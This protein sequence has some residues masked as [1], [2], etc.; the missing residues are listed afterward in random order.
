MKRIRMKNKLFNNADKLIIAIM[1]IVSALMV[2]IQGSRIIPLIDYSFMMENAYRIF[3]GQL[4]YKDFIL[5]YPPGTFFI[6]AKLMNWFGLSNYVQLAYAMLINFLIILITFNV[7]QML[8]NKRV[9]NIFLTLPIIFTGYVIYPFPIYDVNAGFLILLA[10]WSIIYLFKRKNNLLYCFFAG[11]LIALPPLFKQNVG[12][13]FEFSA[14]AMLL[15]SVVFKSK[16]FSL[17][18]FFT[19]ITGVLAVNLSFCIWLYFNHMQADYLYMIFIS[20]SKTRPLLPSLFNMLTFAVSK[21]TL[22]YYLSFVPLF[23]IMPNEKFSQN[24][25]KMALTGSIILSSLIIPFL[26]LKNPLTAYEY[27]FSVWYLVLIAVFTSIF[28]KILHKKI[29]DNLCELIV[30]IVISLTSLSSFLSQGVLGSSYG[31][32]P[33]LMIMIAGLISLFKENID[34]FVLPAVCFSLLL[35]VLL[36]SYNYRLDR[37]AAYINYFGD[38]NGSKYIDYVKTRGNWL[39]DID[40]MVDFVN[41]NIPKEDKVIDLP[42]ED[43]FYLLTGRKPL[44]KYFS[45]NSTAYIYP[46]EKIY[47]DIE[48]NNIQWIIVKNKFQI[49]NSGGFIDISNPLNKIKKNYYLYKNLKAYNV[50]KKKGIIKND[51]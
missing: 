6:M 37:M 42:G 17:K 5:V 31:I 28:V 43:P 15:T 47:D 32:W 26:I 27:Y 39:P 46:I 3:S 23:F 29:Q 40:E 19:V 11:I 16:L 8:N 20:P 21:T 45:L 25:K 2:F 7:L 9:L 12:L 13:I 35:T 34:I 50:Y 4:P 18:H 41:N 51:K 1:G 10:V 24:I 14:I 36:I 49:S 48:L 38:M 44:L 33:L 22:L 30:L